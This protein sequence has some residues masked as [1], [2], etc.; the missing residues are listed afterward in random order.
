NINSATVKVAAVVTATKQGVSI[1]P[2]PV[3]GDNIN[4]HFNGQPLGIY[5]VKIYNGAGQQVYQQPISINNNQQRTVIQIPNLTK[6]NYEL[7]V[8]TTEGKKITIPF[9]K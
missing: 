7:M 4:V 3:V 1:Y 9:L 2:N 5:Q 8:V 6:G